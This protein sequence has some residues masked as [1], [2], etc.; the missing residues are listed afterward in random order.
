[1]LLNEIE[2]IK[3]KL[4][5]TK[6]QLKEQMENNMPREDELFTFKQ[7]EIP[8]ITESYERMI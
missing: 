5:E 2:Q 3:Q 4:A 7:E 1:M 8:K 6:N